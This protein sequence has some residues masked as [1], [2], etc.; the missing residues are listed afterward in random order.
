MS[1]GKYSGISYFGR[2]FE[3]VKKLLTSVQP[4]CLFCPGRLNVRRMMWHSISVGC[5]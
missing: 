2:Y 5:T 3:L 1:E 4:V